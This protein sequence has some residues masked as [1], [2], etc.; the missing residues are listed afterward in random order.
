MVQKQK[1]CWE[2]PTEFCSDLQ[3]D[4][5]KEFLNMTEKE[6]TFHTTQNWKAISTFCG[7]VQRQV[8]SV[9]VEF[10]ESNFIR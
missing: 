2:E 7:K 6:A 1:L 10:L 9:T 5:H 3:M 4:P 8:L